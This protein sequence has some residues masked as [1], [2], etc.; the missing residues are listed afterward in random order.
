MK[1]SRNC[2]FRIQLPRAHLL[3]LH[4]AGTKAG[5]SEKNI[6]SNTTQTT[7]TQD[8]IKNLS[9]PAPAPTS[10]SSLLRD[11]H[12]A[13][14]P[15]VVSGFFLFSSRTLPLFYTELPGPEL[16]PQQVQDPALPSASLF[17]PQNR[18]VPFFSPLF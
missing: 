7:T 12:E 9:A 11:V 13:R 14:N 3:P 17:Y 2:R 5:I 16:V 15:A 8:D 1:Q 6:F 18:A 10:N 4:K